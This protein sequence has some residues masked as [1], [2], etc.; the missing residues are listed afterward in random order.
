ML[1]L[2]S[3]S[4]LLLL[5]GL[6]DVDDGDGEEATSARTSVGELRE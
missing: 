4:E 1:L 3:L 6:I 2:L 5:A